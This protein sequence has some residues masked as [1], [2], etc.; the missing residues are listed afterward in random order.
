V[1]ARYAK[2]RAALAKLGVRVSERSGKGSHV[3]VDDGKGHSYPL[4]LHR[5]TKTE[6]SDVYVRGLCRAL[7]LDYEELRKH[8]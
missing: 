4:P 5:G 6:L 3:V 7:E 1:P 8:L 2:L